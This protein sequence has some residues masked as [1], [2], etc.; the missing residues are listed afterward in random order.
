MRWREIYCPKCGEPVKIPWFWILGIEGIFYCGACR[1]YLRLN[2]RLGALLAG[3]GWALAFVA[4]QLL[5][6]FTSAFTIALAAVVFFPLGFLLS[7]LF[8]RFL[9]KRSVRSK[10]TK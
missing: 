4:V 3:V 5:A 9:L 7:F 2:F 1:Q 8:R 6:Y 10:K